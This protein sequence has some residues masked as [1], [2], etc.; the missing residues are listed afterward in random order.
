MGL[1]LSNFP[2]TVSYYLRERTCKIARDINILNINRIKRF[3]DSQCTINIFLVLLCKSSQKPAKNTYPISIFRCKR[4]KEDNKW[5]HKMI[6]CTSHCREPS[7]CPPRRS[8]WTSGGRIQARHVSGVWRWL[9]R[10]VHYSQKSKPLYR[11]PLQQLYTYT[12][13]LPITCLIIYFFI[14]PLN[15]I[16]KEKVLFRALS[17]FCTL[18]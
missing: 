18:H 7:R 4:L 15:Y 13:P 12:K 14:L 10:K 2:G 11:K 6:Q 5:W 1:V 17:E 8:G 9:E 3:Q 16:Y